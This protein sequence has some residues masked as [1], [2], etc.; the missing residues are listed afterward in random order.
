MA[1]DRGTLAK[2]DR[3]VFAELDHFESVQMVKVPVSDATWS[4]WR[5]YCD[6][7]ELT[8]GEGIAVLIT[9][10]LLSTLDTAGTDRAPF[11]DRIDQLGH[12][13][14]HTFESRDREL[15]TLAKRL[16]DKED[17]LRA[18]EQRWQRREVTERIQATPRRVG[19]NEQ[20]PC[21]SGLKY[22]RCHGRP[23]RSQ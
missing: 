13:R 16:Q 22:K 7:L 4:T 18:W 10:E 11:S 23:S 5:R 12:E 17:Y 3:R 2:I 19:R 1:L 14:V 20:C 8:M 15:A 21:G 6:A 9:H